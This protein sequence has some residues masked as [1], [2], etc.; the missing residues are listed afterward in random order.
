MISRG[1]V[2]RSTKPRAGAKAT[3][4]HDIYKGE[5][6]IA[7]ELQGE[8][9][10]R[11][12]DPRESDAA[13]LWQYENIL[14]ERAYA[15]AQVAH[16]PNAVAFNPHEI[17][18][19][20]TATVFVPDGSAAEVPFDLL[21]MSDVYVW[22]Y[23]FGARMGIL[24][25]LRSHI[26]PT[27]FGVL[28]YSEELSQAAATI[29]SFRVPLVS[30]SKDA[31]NASAAVLRALEE[32]HLATLKA[33][34]KQDKATR[35]EFGENFDVSGYEAEITSPHVAGEDGV[36]MRLDISDDLLDWVE[37]NRRDLAEGLLRALRVHEGVQLGRTA[38]LGLGIPISKAEVEV[39]DAVLDQYSPNA[40]IDA[41]R[42]V[43]HDLN[44]VVA[45]AL[46]LT[47]E[48]L[49]FIERDCSED[50]FVKKIKPRY[51]GSITRKQGF[52]TGLD[53][54]SRYGK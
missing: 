6:I 42:A 29:E 12:F 47:A 7:A 51:P 23:A 16:C 31:A 1:I 2:F 45:R 14:P 41:Q 54:S 33:R 48:E 49:T 4:R 5:N 17:A 27:N 34:M 44:S 43:L 22:F 39:W 13:Y 20:D 50:S 15:I 18:F 3:G 19:T 36:S 21:L 38:I 25:T 52:R 46:G 40:V 32:L 28:P 37:L 26:Y 35:I 11:G 9:S 10:L 8:A 24:R 30:T 53:A